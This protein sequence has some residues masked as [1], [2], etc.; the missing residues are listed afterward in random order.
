MKTVKNYAF[1]LSAPESGDFG[2]QMNHKL[3]IDMTEDELKE[4]V[5]SA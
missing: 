5:R 2:V 4:H 1:W 3:L